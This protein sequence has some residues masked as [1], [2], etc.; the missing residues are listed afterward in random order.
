MITGAARSGAIALQSESW[1]QA[2]IAPPRRV[3]PPPLEALADMGLLGLVSLVWLLGALV[4]H[5]MRALE[6]AGDD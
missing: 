6:R 1:R 2:P 3:V 4:M 5:S